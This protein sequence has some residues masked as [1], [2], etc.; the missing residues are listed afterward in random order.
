MAVDTTR[1]TEC[2]RENR[3]TLLD[4]LINGPRSA[5]LFKLQTGIKSHDYL[6][7]AKTEVN[8][9]DCV[10]AGSDDTAHTF[11][12]RLIAVGCIKVEDKVC[13]HDFENMYLEAEVNTTAGH[14]TLGEAGGVLAH[15]FATAIAN[16]TDIAIWQGDKTSA[17]RNLNKFDGLIKIMTDEADVEK[18]DLTAITDPMELVDALV[19]AIPESAY[20][21]GAD[22][23]T[24]AQPIVIMAATL[25]R[26]LKYR[27][28]KVC[29]DGCNM[30]IVSEKFLDF[31]SFIPNDS[32]VRFIGVPGMN[33]TGKIIGG[34]LYDLY[35]GVDMENGDEQID[36]WWSQDDDAWR[37]RAKFKYGVQIAFPRDMFLA[38]YTGSTVMPLAMPM[39]VGTF[40]G[41]E[42]TDEQKIDNAKAAVIVAWDTKNNE[43]A[44]ASAGVK[45]SNT[46]ALNSAKAALSALGIDA[47]EFI[48][49]LNADG[50]SVDG[51]INTL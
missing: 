26:S 29:Y 1:A 5:K 15:G 46:K 28:R 50:G 13:A 35:L 4:T 16:R 20:L 19:A 7:I 39:G 47:D 48:A 32:D 2:F 17:D 27:L 10:C 49:T 34:S 41:T 24:G 21:R 8:F 12:D 45:S 3:E 40:A 14:E 6:H 44:D 11:I 38:T 37:Q 18:I 22:S 51:D 30:A 23:P 25:L 33:G 36:G 31:D 43:P 9:G 42:L